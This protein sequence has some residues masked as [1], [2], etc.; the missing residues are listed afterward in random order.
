MKDSETEELTFGRQLRF[1]KQSI[2]KSHSITLKT[3]EQVQAG[4][5]LFSDLLEKEKPKIKKI[6]ITQG[7]NEKKNK[8]L[9]RN[10]AKSSL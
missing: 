7:P 5:L 3:H 2:G 8:C 1:L 9:F 6:D 10:Y 4:I